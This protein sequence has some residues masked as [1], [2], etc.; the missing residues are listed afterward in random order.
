M[1]SLRVPLVEGKAS[2]Y[3]KNRLLFYSITSYK[4]TV[5]MVLVEMGV[6]IEKGRG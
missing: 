6:G 3:I 1:P 5:M 2:A 4:V